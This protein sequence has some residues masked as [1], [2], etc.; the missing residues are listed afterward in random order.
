MQFNGNEPLSLPVQSRSFYEV[1]VIFHY[2]KT[3]VV[4][5]T[6]KK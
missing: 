2:M 6:L 1:I 4:P 3:I 5:K